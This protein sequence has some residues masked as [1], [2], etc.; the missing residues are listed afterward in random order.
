MMLRALATPLR[1]QMRPAVVQAA[2]RPVSALFS[3]PLPRA[4]VAMRA[5]SGGAS[6]AF[7]SPA[8]V[9]ER[10]IACLKNFNKVDPAKVTA[11]SHFANDLGLDSLDQARFAL[12]VGPVAAAATNARRVQV[13][14][15]MALEED[16][17]ITIPDDQAE[18]ILTVE[19]AVSFI[20]KHP[21]AR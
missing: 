14:V 3:S 19:D 13:E 17:V 7:L 9:T 21:Q 5:F 20:S 15:V 16:F 10:I 1:A 11:K 8:E 6:D 4:P 2:H 12:G 18:K